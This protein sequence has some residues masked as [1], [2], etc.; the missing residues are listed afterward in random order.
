MKSTKI[1][2]QAK[3]ILSSADGFTLIELLIGMAI[4]TIVLAAVIGVYSG[5]IRSYTTETARAGA[6][7]DIRSALAIMVQD[8]RLAGLDPL[9]TAG[10]GFTVTGN[11]DIE[12][13]ADLDFDGA[14]TAGNSERIRYF[15]NGNRLM[16]RLDDDNTTDEVLLDD[17]SALNFNY[18]FEDGAAAPSTVVITLTV[19]AP[20][21]RQ[22]MI[23][24]TLSER[25]RIRNL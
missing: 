1:R 12:C 6:Q 14:V 7:Q 5:L 11:T 9:R 10:G 19:Q 24:R 16:Q 8:I 18:I 13:I 4:A 23:T 3:P 20:A 15:L 22:G 2:R 21:G 25:V 17:V